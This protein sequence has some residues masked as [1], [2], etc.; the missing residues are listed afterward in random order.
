V[1]LLAAYDQAKM[2]MDALRRL[3]ADERREVLQLR[4]DLDGQR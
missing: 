1:R 3:L 4:A 2:E